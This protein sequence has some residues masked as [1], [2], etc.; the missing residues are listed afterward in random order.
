MDLCLSEE[1][2]CKV[3]AT[4]EARIWTSLLIPLF[5]K[6]PVDVFKVKKWLKQFKNHE[7]GNTQGNL[8]Y[9]QSF[10]M[11]ILRMK[12]SKAQKV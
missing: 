6:L 11:I 9:Y 1:Y 8:N 10:I 7:S 3:N 12:Q 4:Y 5:G 2:E